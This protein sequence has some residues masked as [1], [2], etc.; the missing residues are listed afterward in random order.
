[1]YI[2]GKQQ[3]DLEANQW[4]MMENQARYTAEKANSLVDEGDSYLAQRLLMEVMP[5]PQTTETEVA[6]RNAARHNSAILRGHTWSVNSV[7]FNSDGRRI[8]SG[9]GDHSVIIWDAEDGGMVGSFALK[10]KDG[11]STWVSSASLSPDDETLATIADDSIIYL[12]K[13]DLGLDD[14]DAGLICDKEL[15]G[16]AAEV[17]SVHFSPDGTKIVS[18][19]QD[20]TIRVWDPKTGEGHVVF[21]LAEAKIDYRGYPAIA[22]F[23]PDGAKIIAAYGFETLY[24]LDAGTGKTIKSWPTYFGTSSIDISPDGKLIVTASY[25]GS[26]N[27]VYEVET[28]EK[29]QEFSGGIVAVFNPKGNLIVSGND[30]SGDRMIRVWKVGEDEPV[31]ILKGH[32]DNVNAVA[33]SPDGKRIVSASCDKTIRLW[34]VYGAM[35]CPFEENEDSIGGYPFSPDGNY[36]VSYN[37]E[38][39]SIWNAKTH[40][41]I[42]SFEDCS[43]YLVFTSYSPDGKLVAFPS[44][45][46]S[47]LVCD[48]ETGTIVNTFDDQTGWKDMIY[49]ISFSPDG[50]QIVSARIDKI[51]VW[52]VKT[53]NVVVSIDED[54][55]SFY[56]AAF[57]PDGMK[58]VSASTNTSQLSLDDYLDDYYV[59]VWDVETGKLLHKM[60][61][62]RDVNVAFFSP[63]GTRIVSASDDK[64]VRIWDVESESEWLKLEHAEKVYC[65]SYSPDG[66]YI[67][68]VSWEGVYV[69]DAETGERIQFIADDYVSFAFFSSNGKHIITDNYVIPFPSLQ[70]LIDQTHERFKER[71]LTSE[72]RRMYYLE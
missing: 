1:M 18:T 63:D 6:L 60:E 52:D 32:A 22:I 58:I 16:H 9:S 33:F 2:I 23:S 5:Y 7:A 19:S 65:A 8:V 70:D 39:F 66:K 49:S 12:W 15:V 45:K 35:V 29:L 62:D 31:R 68:S 41:V 24:V 64:T 56:S 48:V 54:N 61:H 20:G 38:S 42:K 67:V 25:S 71:P 57:S 46:G 11:K 44:R 30:R 55:M 17:N 34:D 3:R 69:W 14:R 47:I 4:R 28:G 27:C 36:H 26:I 51:R 10:T 53:G 43:S 40:E 13:L 50:K 21:P 72:E 37:G 59:C